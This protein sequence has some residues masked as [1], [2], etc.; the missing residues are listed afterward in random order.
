MF[1]P[2]RLGAVPGHLPRHR[3]R[4]ADLE[5]G[6]GIFDKTVIKPLTA[7]ALLYLM[8][9]IPKKLM[10]VASL[11]AISMPG[12]GKMGSMASYAGGKFAQQAISRHV[13]EAF[14]GSQE[15]AQERTQRRQG[16]LD[17]KSND[18]G[19]KRNSE[20]SQAAKNAAQTAAGMGVAASTGGTGTAATGRGGRGK[21]VAN[22]PGPATPGT[23]NTTG[24]GSPEYPT[25][26][27]RPRRAA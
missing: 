8:I 16:P 13:P 1:I 7:I 3:V 10:Q 25:A 21:T 11:G 15:M 23:G 5:G 2:V 19:N 18:G 22:G 4:H 9:W 27:R 17:K 12:S 14:G 6:G 26:R 24:S 20:G